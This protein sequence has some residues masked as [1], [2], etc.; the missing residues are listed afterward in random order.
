MLHAAW[1]SL[2]LHI[3]YIAPLGVPTRWHQALAGSRLK[4]PLQAKRYKCRFPSSLPHDTQLSFLV[5]YSNCIN[6]ARFLT[7]YNYAKFHAAMI[8]IQRNEHISDVGRG[9][10]GAKS[11]SERASEFH[12]KVFRATYML[13]SYAETQNQFRHTVYKRVPVERPI[14]WYMLRY[15]KNS[16]C[17]AFPGVR[18]C[19]RHILLDQYEEWIFT[20]KP[21]LGSPEKLQQW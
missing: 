7:V 10:L 12:W 2:L 16:I 8:L 20:H 4:S 14:I 5:V 1:S 21:S 17:S 13:L 9:H 15:S 6:H 11:M 19:K 3:S 18:S